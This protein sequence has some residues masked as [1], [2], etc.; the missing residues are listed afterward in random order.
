MAG[1]TYKA[2]V[3]DYRE[4][5]WDPNYTPRESD[6]LAVFKVVPQEG[7]PREEAAAAVCAE[8]STAT[9]TTVW[10][11]LLTD[12]DYYKGRAY[13]I[14][15]VPGDDEAFYAFIAY[16]MGLFEEGSVVNVF[17]SLV[18]NVFGFK[19]VRFLRLEDVRF[20]LWFVTTCDGPPHGIQVERDKLDKYGRAL[21]GCTIK[22]KLGLSAKN[23]GR[24]V[25]ECL[26]GGLDF[27]KDDENVN[28]Q[29]FMRWRDR[30]LFCQEAIEKAEAETGE[31]KGHYLNVTAPNVEEMYK[32]AEFAKEIGTPI[33]MSDYLTIGWAAH[34]SL[35]RWCRDN[36]MLLHV[37]RAMH[38]VIDRNPKHGI[39]FRVLAKL[40]RLLGG[41]HLHSGTVVG[42]LE[43]DRAAT[44]GWIDLMRERVVKE[45]RARGIFFDQ[46]WGQMPS[47]FPVAS[48]GIH[49]WHMPAL[50]SIFGDESVLQFGGGTIGHPW[51]NAAGACANRVALEACTQ[52]RNEGRHLEKEGKDILTE[53]AKHSPELKIAME[54]WKEIKF[55]FD[56]V[57]KLDV[58]H[59]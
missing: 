18:G 46:D 37:H 43:G 7:V 38:G 45:D 57:D 17:T 5:Y 20:P 33:I 48:G 44:L 8:S 24:A 55:E 42:K 27:T 3:K 1:K 47:V 52:A 19:A 16:P 4:T 40:L 49:V 26:R 39:N 12:L 53:A 28:S 23:Y 56:T 11:D 58:A 22:P 14:E 2:G 10:T 32:R 41:D 9:W 34:S 15:D 51:G 36:G 35:S 30:F 13:A 50:V 31:R 21:L 54:T 59:R 25:Y 29:P 6:F